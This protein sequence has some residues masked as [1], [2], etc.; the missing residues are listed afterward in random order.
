[1]SLFPAFL[2]CL[3]QPLWLAAREA[4]TGFESYLRVPEHS[5]TT[6][7]V[8]QA[9]VVAVGAV[10]RCLGLIEGPAMSSG[11][12]SRTG[13]ARVAAGCVHWFVCGPRR[14]R[15]ARRMARPLNHP[16]SG[17]WFARSLGWQRRSLG[18][19]LRVAFRGRSPRAPPGGA[20]QR[21]N[22][23]P[24]TAVLEPSLF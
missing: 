14:A 1:M 15:I 13:G 11:L 2:P 20:Q 10:V 19:G 12:A 24:G 6:K 16:V 4:Q 9:E 23:A 22:S 18:A 3:C 21:L 5:S 7:G 8:W 17:S